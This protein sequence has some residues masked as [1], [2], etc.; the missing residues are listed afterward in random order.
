MDTRKLNSLTLQFVPYSDISSLNSIE[1]IKKLLK[2]VLDNKIVLMQGRLKAEEESR[3]IEDT[4]A[5]IGSVKGFRG[6]ELAVLSP[7]ESGSVVGN[8]KRGLARMLVGENDSITIIGPASVVREMRRD[9]NK[10][11]LLLKDKSRRR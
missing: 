1:R 4:M 11:Q 7:K 10:I 5:L 3:L 8:F 6:I 9:P 2:V